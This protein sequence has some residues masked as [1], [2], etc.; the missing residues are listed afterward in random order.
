MNGYG[1]PVRRFPV[2]ALKGLGNPAASDIPVARIADMML[3][4]G[5]DY[6][7]DGRTQRYPDIRLV[8]WCGGNPFHHHQDLNRLR[9]AWERPETIVVNEI[10][11]TPT[12]KL[13]DIVLP[14]TTTLER[15]DIGASSRDRYIM[16]M[17]Q[18]VEPVGE[19][20]NDFDIFGGLAARLGIAA[21]FT[22]GRG[23]GGVAAPS[24]RRVAP[25]GSPQRSRAAGFR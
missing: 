11:W 6:D 23:R 22:E 2:P 15:N 17:H 3:R 4:P 20:R 10:W 8:Y 14:A 16:A 21:A 5:E 13:A 25:A 1:N 19:A 24:L 7:F 12:A 18:V 9:R